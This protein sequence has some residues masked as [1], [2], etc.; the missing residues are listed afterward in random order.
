[1]VKRRRFANQDEL[2]VQLK[3]Y[4][5]GVPDEHIKQVLDRLVELGVSVDQLVRIE[6]DE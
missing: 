1:V 5:S 2:V 4:A 3:P 6:V